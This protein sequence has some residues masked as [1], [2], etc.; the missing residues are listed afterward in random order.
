MKSKAEGINPYEILIMGIK[1]INP[2]EILIMG[3]SGTFTILMVTLS[4]LIL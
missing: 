4:S 1:G 2:Y 3:I